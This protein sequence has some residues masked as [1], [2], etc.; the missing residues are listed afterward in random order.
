ML[1]LLA[2][3]LTALNAETSVPSPAVA[4][5]LRCEFLENP[6][7]IGTS[8]PRL[9]F[10]MQDGR[11]GARP[12]GWQVLAATEPALLAPG[13]ADLWD[14]GLVPAGPA[15][16]ATYA[17]VPLRSRMRVFWSVRLADHEGRFT[18]FA[19]P[20]FFETAF[21][22]PS[23][24]TA[25]WI[26]PPL[27]DEPPDLSD[28]RF[29]WHDEGD[30]R[31]SAP[32]ARRA[33]RAAFALP[34]DSIVTVAELIVAADDEFEAFVNGR[35]AGRG[36]GFR[37][38]H[39]LAVPEL[40]DAG[41]NHLAI[42][43]TNSGGPAA[44]AFLL[45]IR[46]HDGRSIRIASGRHRVLS[47][48]ATPPEVVLPGCDD[49][50]WTA[51]RIVGTPGDAPWGPTS[52]PAGPRGPCWIWRTFD[53]DEPASARLYA[54][55]LGAFRIFV[56]GTRAGDAH[57]AP[58]FT[59]YRRRVVHETLDVTSSLRRGRNVIAVLLGD[60]WYGGPLGWESLR[61]PFGPPPPRVLLELHVTQRDG[62]SSVVASD[63]AWLASPSGVL[64]ADLYG[65]EVRDARLDPDPGDSESLA[66]G[67]APV[68]LPGGPRPRPV[69]RSAPPI[70]AT[71]TIAPVAMHKTQDGRIIADFGRNFAGFVRLRVRGTESVRVRLRFAESVEEAGELDRRN[72]RG[73]AATDVFICDG[74]S[75]RTFE[76]VFTYHGFRFAEIEGLCEPPAP[77]DVTG[78]VAHSDVAPAGTFEC[79]D[80]LLN[81]LFRNLLESLASNLMSVPTDCPQRDERLG[82]MGDAAVIWDTA[83]HALDMAAFSN[84]W[85]ADV[86]DA[87]SDVGAFSDVSPRIVVDD[88]G[89]P[90]WA[91]AGVLVPVATFLHTGDHRVL[92]D[93]WPSMERFMDFVAAANPAALRE[94][95]RHND[96][97]DWI[98]TDPRTPKELLATA[99]WAADAEAMAW[100]A[101]RLGRPDAAARHRALHAT[102][103]SAFARRHVDARGIVGPGTQ[104]CQALA[105]ACHLVPPELRAPALDHL[106]RDIESRGGHLSTGFLGTAHVL[107]VLSEHGRSD[108]AWRL[109]RQTTFPSW[110]FMV[111]RG[112]TSL[113][114]RWDGH[115][116][117]PSMNSFNHF[118]L[119]SF[120]AWLYRHGLG[121][122]CA[123]DGPGFA[124][125]E[126][127]PEVGPEAPA[128]VRGSVR[129]VRG[130][131]E[132]AWTRTGDRG[133]VLA[134][135]IPPGEDVTLTLP[136][137]EGALITEGGVDVPG[138]PGI[139]ILRRDARSAVLRIGAGSW[140]FVV[141]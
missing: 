11:R 29:V 3:A 49:S 30:P 141:S 126:I 75:P 121:L 65:G 97:G 8:A 44:L 37:S 2:M 125:V 13:M 84:K 21:L 69:A 40:L 138:A 90:G 70:R 107:S 63:A 54:T 93:S 83:F 62:R 48:A 23:E 67:A 119:G 117:S 4:A 89:A 76:P 71:R 106:V 123:G 80:P 111:A 5:R 68:T 42:V 127:A 115:T 94:N 81:T 56:N 135:R 77:G 9:S 110:G 28:V 98:A 36:I 86:R 109:L 1:L 10:E 128:S 17:G 57:L 45:R 72:L 114:E 120:G 103:A 41:R 122:R 12:T 27:D 52:L 35:P 32:A 55:A 101:E 116:A 14:T 43:A 51:A 61:F 85:L 78:V 46:L 22:D 96:Y 16:A 18:P 134:L 129:T 15:T 66:R 95:G 50:A 73:A 132:I 124:R 100:A 137:P 6:L 24:W 38:F 87:Q 33:F 7:G 140:R 104:T 88:D 112:A 60:G 130:L 39:R 99:L 25:S 113:W 82:W 139:T 59:D 92:L 105:L 64:R 58:D 34:P 118:A 108:L 47:S 74:R 26:A 53:L 79:S 20:A 131:F 102:I 91:D 31:V 136:A 19:R 133:F